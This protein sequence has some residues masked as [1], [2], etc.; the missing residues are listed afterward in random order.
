MYL[1]FGQYE[2]Q[3]GCCPDSNG[4]DRANGRIASTSNSYPALTREMDVSS[5][6][7]SNSSGKP[8]AT[9]TQPETEEV[10]VGNSALT[11]EIRHRAYEIYLERGKQSGHD[12]DDWLQAEQELDRVV[13]GRVKAG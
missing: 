4:S 7:K 2:I 9:S 10:P 6:L 5:K 11:E 1:S 8:Q 12:V 13:L 3:A